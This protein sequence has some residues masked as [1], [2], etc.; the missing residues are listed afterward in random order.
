MSLRTRI[1]LCLTLNNFLVVL[2][3]VCMASIS[4][5]QAATT[6]GHKNWAGKGDFGGAGLL[7]TR[8]ARSSADGL[9]E[10][11]FSNIFPYKR[12][13]LTLQALPWLEG[14]FRY[15]DIENRLFSPFASFSGTQ[16]F[17]DRG[18]DLSFRL[19]EES[20]YVPA[21]SITLQDGLGTGQFSGE[22]LSA[23]KRFYDLD[24]TGGIA[25]GYGA[26]SQQ[27]ENPLA[28]LSNI[29][30]A[31]TGGG[32]TGGQLN[33]S[34]YLSGEN[35]ALY[36]GVAYR[37]PIKGLVLKFEYDPNDYQAE[38]QSNVFVSDSHFNYGL[39][40]RPFEW[41]EASA[42]VERGNSYM[43]RFALL[44]NLHDPGLPKS[45]A[46]PQ[47]IKPR[48]EVEEDLIKYA[49]EPEKPWWYLPAF[50]DM[51]KG[52]E[53]YLPKLT[54]VDTANEHAVAQMFDGF[55]REGIGIETIETNH[56]SV[57][58]VL[59][60]SAYGESHHNFESMAK[61]VAEAF[62]SQSE[63]ITFAPK[64]N[65][66]GI[67]SRVS[68]KDLEESE[69][70]D[71]LFEGL[72]SNGLML[73]DLK[74]SHDKAHIVISMMDTNAQVTVQIAQLVLRSLPTP[75]KEISMDLAS[76]GV[77]IRK[78]S[79]SRDEVER[80]ALVDDLFSNLESRGIGVSE[81]DISDTKI[82]LS[83][84]RDEKN[85][86][87]DYLEIASIIEDATA[88]KLSE[89]TIVEKV[90]DGGNIRRVN[91]HR[92][93]SLGDN[94]LHW[95]ISS[96][97]G[98]SENK[99]APQWSVGDKE[100]LTE[101]LFDV[102][103]KDGIHA[104]A[105]DINGFRVTIYGATRKFRQS[106]RN[107]GRA[108][109]AIANNVPSEIEEL[110]FVAMSAGMEMSRTLIRRKDLEDA[111][112]KNSSVDEIWA[113]G[114]ISPPKSG[115]FF[116]DSAIKAKHR[117]PTVDWTFKPK[118]KNHLGGPDQFL[119]YELYLTAGFDIGVFRGLNLTGRANR[120]LFD[121]FDKIQFGSSSVL[122][123]VRTDIKEYLQESKKYSI[124]RAQAN[125]YF[126]PVDEWYAR[127]SAGIFEQMFG[128]YGFEVL[129]RPFNSRLSVG[130]D[131]NKVWQ[132]GFE[133]RFKFR[134][135]SVNTGHLN[136]YYEFPWYDVLGNVKVGQ[137]LA[138]DRGATFTASRRFDSGVMMG[139]WATFTDVSAED[140][141]EGSFDKG[142]Y[143][144]IPFELFL[145]SSTKQTGTFAFRPITR[146]GGGT[147]GVQGRLYGVTSGGSRG[148][149]MREWNR[150][151]D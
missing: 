133:Q 88:Y 72:E 116:P 52:L 91:V 111:D 84:V 115:I 66:N 142:F 37:T 27:F 55:S 112:A 67:I 147:L 105:I 80:E 48:S 101:R 14:T 26:R 136:V 150:F 34:T 46:L 85:S 141:G 100:F 138:G 31:R 58:I 76:A 64:S 124:G 145:T 1:S 120:S 6:K 49:K 71:H 56:D 99:L 137:Y 129:H 96:T 148:E 38:P 53:E 83:I 102:L 146:D 65:E 54:E 11:G 9:F 87:A 8:T 103:R 97:S 25:W 28:K 30:V 43:F 126:S 119:L 82:E 24:I 121:N 57:K 106:A 5:V 94:R 21:V 110:E 62:P 98:M 130:L 63:Q 59:N 32:V 44:S 60:Q 40:Y 15:T 47:K 149:V 51:Q 12:Y 95:A 113:K 29:F 36:G 86:T 33:V 143:M 109:R 122:P 89:V 135:Y 4:V 118:L 68:R 81:I 70:V 7:Q 114:E 20:K 45:E 123:H 22:Y 3:C 42:A 108:M 41:F 144:R 17:K 23:T 69:V 127:A 92:K 78:M 2:F 79:F 13:Y 131:V 128:G 19:L 35:V 151:L 18:A 77:T 74:L 139:I 93:T 61:L 132:R 39:T 107:I 50:G 73:E 125:Y 140:F 75:V 134:D 10:V 16:T 90:L 104:D 117:Y